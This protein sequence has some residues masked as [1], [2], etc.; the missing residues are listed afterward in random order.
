MVKKE[1]SFV[2]FF[3]EY[4]DPVL[5]TLCGGYT[6]ALIGFETSAQNEMP[7]DGKA[8]MVALGG[9]GATFFIDG[10][11]RVFSGTEKLG[12]MERPEGKPHDPPRGHRPAPLLRE[13]LA[14]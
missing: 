11:R 8:A 7:H 6:L 1:H 3:H 2:A 14:A 13:D 10:S 9:L 4:T 5:V 12:P